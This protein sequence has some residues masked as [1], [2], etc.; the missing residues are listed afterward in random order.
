VWTL[1]E[2][3]SVVSSPFWIRWL[4]RAIFRP[5]GPCP[6]C[7]GRRRIGNSEMW[8]DSPYCERCGDKGEQMRLSA[9]IVRGGRGW[10]K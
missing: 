5:K 4:W 10:G 2:V 7:R 8:R 1:L 9:R 3:V 6:D